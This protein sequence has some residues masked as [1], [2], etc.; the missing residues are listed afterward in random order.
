VSS[1]K[2][3]IDLITGEGEDPKFFILLEIGIELNKIEKDPTV[4][5]DAKLHKKT[6]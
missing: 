3:G 1:L 2:K 6:N 5:D 4:A